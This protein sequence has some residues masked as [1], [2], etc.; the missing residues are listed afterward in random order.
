MHDYRYIWVDP[1]FLKL[2]C[3]S[4]QNLLQCQRAQILIPYDTQDS[5][6]EFSDFLAEPNVYVLQKPLI[7]HAFEQR[8]TAQDRAPHKSGLARSVRFASQVELFIGNDKE[9]AP[10]APPSQPV[11]RH[12]ILLVE[13]NPINQK[14]GV[15]MLR[16]LGYDTVTALDGDDAIRQIIK[17]DSTVDLILMDQSMP[18]KDGVTATKEIRDLEAEG[19]LFR[20][21]PII[22]VTAVVSSEAQVQFKAAGA[23]DFLAKPLS[24]AKLEQTLATYL[25][26]D[27]T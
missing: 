23:D 9:R 8:I 5:I 4:L 17:H 2:N 14:L 18:V 20:K 25:H 11:E 24:L 15:K 3:N 21:R 1:M 10:I 22:A 26:E 12:V 27:K 6:K 7:W 16:S 19:V 13:D